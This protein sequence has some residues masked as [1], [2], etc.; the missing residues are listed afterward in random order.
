[1]QENFGHYSVLLD[2][3]GEDMSLEMIDHDYRDVEGYAQGLGER[4]PD[5]KGAEQPRTPRE[6]NGSQITGSHSGFRKSLAHDRY[7]ILFMRPRGKFRHDSAEIL[8][9]LLAR[10]H[11][12]E[13]VTVSDDCGR[14]VVTGRLD[15]EDNG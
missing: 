1:M 12:R 11:V 10:N 4:S 5:K 2:E 15:S 7:D 6:C 8:V 9:N 14:C 13:E 3:T